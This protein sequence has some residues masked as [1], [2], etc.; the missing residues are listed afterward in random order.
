MLEADINLMEQVLINLVVNAIEA[1]KEQ[2]EPR[3]IFR[4]IMASNN[5]TVIKV[6][7]NGIGYAGGI[8]G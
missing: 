1:V 5:K 8:A 6:A 7:D 3:I 4:P 2:D